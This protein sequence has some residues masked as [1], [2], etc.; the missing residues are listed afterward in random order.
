M[1]SE[2]LLRKLLLISASVFLLST[3]SVIVYKFGFQP[4]EQSKNSGLLI[5]TTPTLSPTSTLMPSQAPTS[6]KQKQPTDN[7]AIQTRLQ[8]LDSRIAM[9]K[10]KIAE[11]NAF[12]EQMNK[13]QPDGAVFR[14]IGTIQANKELQAELNT[15]QAE[16]T[17][18]LVNQ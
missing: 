1:V 3:A 6:A 8:E 9:I 17:Q 2:A 14:I 18:I 13:E 16:R 5:Q 4:F 12:I 10:N 15:L 7:S 11:N